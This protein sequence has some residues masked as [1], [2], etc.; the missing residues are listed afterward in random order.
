MKNLRINLLLLGI[1]ILAS[2]LRIY[3]LN[4]DQGFHL[5]PDER[6]IVMY[7][8]PL[9]FPSN[10]SEFFSPQSPLN[11]RFFA[12]GSFPIYLLKIFGSIA[13]L[14]NP[15]F[16]TYAGINII[17]RIISVFAD[18][19]V[20]LVIFSL[21]RKLFNQKVALFSSFFY[22]ISVFPLQT[23]H[24]YAVDTLLSLF[25]LATLYMLSFFY[26][27]PSKKKALLI[28]LFFGLSL[29]TK[30]S[31]LPLIISIGL[32]LA[33]D[34]LFIFL[35]Q[36]HKPHIWFSHLPIFLK[37][38]F[39]EG[40]IIIF[41]TII[42]FVILEPYAILD[43]PQFQKQTLEQYQMTHNA[44][45][46]PYTLQYVGKIPYFYELKNIFL[47]GEGPFLAILAFS[48]TIYVTVSLIK[49][50][51]YKLIIIIAFFFTY[52][53]VT[54]SF[55]IGF[56]RYMLPLYPLLSV[57]AG[58]FIYKLS[59][60]LKIRIGNWYLLV[61][62]VFIGSIF[63]WTLS[64]LNIYTKPNTRVQ[65][66]YWINENIP[67]GKTI[68]I[69]HWDDS[70]PLFGAQNYNILTLALYNQDTPQKW[71]II[72]T[73]LRQTDYIIIASNRLYVPLQKLTDCQ[74][75]FPNPCYRETAEYY[76]NLF[77][78]KLRF[79]KVAEFAI[80][81]KIPFTNID[82]N[83]QNADESFTV[84]DHPKVMI[85]KKNDK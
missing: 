48:G 9:H 15:S 14:L 10:A 62:L 61:V 34:F 29:A 58:V 63:T 37:R 2:F 72:N 78:G 73:E 18:L 59:T 76:K 16:A 49:K 55:A 50:I 44:F 71:S 17:G 77:S 13:G 64:F 69:E 33:I 23:S 42:T 80:Y 26:E 41:G 85:F 27:K 5:H 65:A 39:S 47:W 7:A 20:I 74:K 21:A 1:L 40:L 4:W 66:S 82:I 24:F 45:V 70:L 79:E 56:M 75:L 57:F 3:G 6:A 32:A 28:G 83:D 35:R 54:G 12:Y 11:P 22:A 31:A 25:I 84:Y 60:F 43:F 30:V 52:F 19:V 36:P 8:L 68:A 67:Q 81:P 46:F 38:L 53:L 51:N